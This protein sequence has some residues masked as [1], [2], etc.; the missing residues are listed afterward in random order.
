MTLP[1]PDAVFA[2]LPDERPRHLFRTADIPAIRAAHASELGTLR[3]NVELALSDGLPSPPLYHADSAALPYREYFGRFRDFCDRDLVACAL[4]SW[5]LEDTALAQRAAAHAKRLLLAVCD[6][7]P[8]GPA[9]PDSP[10]GDEVGLSL[11]RCLPAVFDLLLPRLTE[12]ETAYVASTV[13][14][15]ASRCERRILRSDYLHHPGNSHVGRLPGYVGE[16]ALVLWGLP[17][18]ARPV[19][20]SELHRWLALALHIYGTL[21]PYYGGDDGAWAEG[22]FYSTSYTKWY[23]PFFALVRRCSPDA[24]LFSKPF[25]RNYAR[26]LLEFAR[27]DHENHPFGDGYWCTPDSPE[28]PGF[29]AQNPFRFYAALSGLPEAIS[30]DRALAAP[31]LF[32]LHLLDV[33]L[34]EPP[35]PAAPPAP[36][37]NAVAFPDIGFASLHS[38]RAHPETDLHVLARASSFGPGSH[39]HADQGAFALFFGGTAL[40]GPSGYF[41]REYGTR[42]HVG[43]T[44]S[45]KAHCTLLADGKGQDWH[46]PN[47]TG[48]V[49]SCAEEN[50]VST[51]VLDLSAA[52]PQLSSWTRTLRVV[53]ASTLV[54]E[55]RVEAPSP[56]RLTSALHS[57]SRPA[58]DGRHAW[59]TR[60]GVRLD[61]EPDAEA[62]DTLELSDAYDIDLN[63]GVP[64]P[65][66]VTMPPQHHL[67]YET[68][69]R[70]A[71]NLRMVF[72]ITRTASS[73]EWRNALA[74]PGVF[75]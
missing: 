22:A 36:P 12:A 27:P 11:A 59:L 58:A 74:L 42:H 6:W 23:L 7:N 75:P 30:L 47:A 43:W 67:Y 72:R 55:D 21:F 26:F 13:A 45:S 8:D 60:N 28:W 71:H 64:E 40:L 37:T 32:S 10:W 16:A 44:R 9:S 39:R 62:F 54:V 69:P 19:P 34:P 33:F 38:D 70:Q 52:Y 35:G 29:F 48:R 65:Y 73:P 49:V 31:R 57:L 3:R 2:G 63:E 68:P 20:E 53:D 50:G 1:T 66:R 25:Y 15:Y 18:A 51:A 41:G 17:R 4:G 46:D 56:V 5:L 24:H 14:A 61:I